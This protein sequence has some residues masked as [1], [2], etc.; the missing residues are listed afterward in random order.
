MTRDTSNGEKK[1]N[2]GHWI[3]TKMEKISEMSK[4][5]GEAL[6]SRAEASKEL[7]YFGNRRSYNNPSIDSSLEGK[8]AKQAFSRDICFVFGG[9][10][11]F[12]PD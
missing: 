9:K 8:C 7:K 12:V 6:A 5:L 3:F 10:S 1:R 11:R 2:K 4:K